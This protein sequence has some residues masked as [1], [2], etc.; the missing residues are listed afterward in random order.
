MRRAL[1]LSCLALLA[2]TGPG[3]A[4]DVYTWKDAAGVSHYSQ[5]PP[6]AGVRYQLR[7]I[8]QSGDAPATTGAPDTRTVVAPVPATP[9]DGSPQAQCQRARDN[10]AVLETDGPVRQAGADGQLRELAPSER[11]DQLQLARAAVRAY[12][13]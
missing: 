2:S 9:D 11:V 6:P 13:G 8:R 5:T 1:A 12:C 7:S 3:L 10:I 4:S